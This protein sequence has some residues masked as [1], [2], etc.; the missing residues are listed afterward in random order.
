[1]RCPACRSVWIRDEGGKIDPAKSLSRWSFRITLVFLFLP[2]FVLFYLYLSHAGSYH[3]L[4]TGCFLFSQ[5]NLIVYF[6]IE[7]WCRPNTHRTAAKFTVQRCIV[8]ETGYGMN[9][10]SW[11]HQKCSCRPF[12][13]TQK[14]KTR[15]NSEAAPG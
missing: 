7:G 14:G 10:R 2:M 15:E 3:L 6:C 9:C 1:M 8:M 5:R 12:Q 4:R 13:Y 11:H